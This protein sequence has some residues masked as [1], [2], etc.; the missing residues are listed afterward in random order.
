MTRRN[1]KAKANGADRPNLWPE[2]PPS[3]LELAVFAWL[4]ALGA[5]R[6]AQYRVE[7]LLETKK[8]A[9]EAERAAA[10]R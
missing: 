4:G 8:H 6:K 9:A 10:G 5:V 3:E 7:A 1:P 2:E